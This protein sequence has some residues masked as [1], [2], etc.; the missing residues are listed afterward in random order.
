MT[1]AF[2]QGAVSLFNGI[3][4]INA[5][6]DRL[7]RSPV[8]QHSEFESL[9]SFA[10]SV[11]QHL[12]AHDD[13][14]RNPKFLDGVG[15]RAQQE[16]ITKCMPEIWKLHSN[17][18]KLGLQVQRL[19]SHRGFD[20]KVLQSEVEEVLLR[21][22]SL[23]SQRIQHVEIVGDSSR[24]YKNGAPRRIMVGE[25]ELAQGLAPQKLP[26][27]KAWKSD[28]DSA[29]I[30]KNF[31][32][33]TRMMNDILLSRI[34][35]IDERIEQRMDKIEKR[36]DVISSLFTVLHNDIKSIQSNSESNQLENSTDE[37]GDSTS[38]VPTSP[39]EVSEEHT[40]N[41]TAT[42]T[43]T[44][45]IQADTK[46]T[47]SSSE[48]KQSDG[49]LAKSPGVSIAESSMETPK[50]SYQSGAAAGRAAFERSKSVS[51]IP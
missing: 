50:R 26:V 36:V 11:H 12:V 24:R 15:E 13:F 29:T 51:K 27:P 4:A 33:I 20:N 31:Q 48:H 9:R 38:E 3:E 32:Q 7:E 37:E 45:N 44:I 47:D 25:E 22:A 6:I 2:V 41:K 14:I 46:L 1:D 43:C 23:G 5:R 34:D 39:P 30:N 18:D 16:V 28:S 8:V 19:Q 42:R 35:E 40:V 21:L 49:M 17:I 10:L